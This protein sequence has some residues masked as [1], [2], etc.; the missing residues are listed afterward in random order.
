[1]T[2]LITGATGQIGSLIVERLAARGLGAKLLTTDPKKR[3]FPAGMLPVKGDLIDPTSMR[4]ALAGVET[5]FLMNAVSPD[6]L[7]K[8]LLALDLAREAG[9]RHVVYLSQVNTDFPDCPHAAAK[10]SAEAMIRYYG[11]AATILRPSYFFQNDAPLREQIVGGTYPMPIGSV[12]AAMVD[13][14][15]IADIAALA[16]AEPAAIDGDPVVEIVGPDVLTGD[17]VAQVW[18]ELLRRPVQY[19]GDNLAVFEANIGQQ[20]PGWHARDLAAMFSGCQ[21]DGMVGRPGAV[22][23]LTALLGGAP[24]SYCAFAQE[25]VAIWQAAP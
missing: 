13:A 3:T 24:R 21:R 2:I 12:G 9:I 10:K 4:A 16:L 19:A 7:T 25:M 17:G 20:L 15:D 22:E 23:R 8:A 6:E 1:M 5:L 18:S 11:M 14:R